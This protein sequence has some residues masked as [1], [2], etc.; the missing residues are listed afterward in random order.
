MKKHEDQTNNFYYVT[1]KAHEKWIG[2]IKPGTT[3][4]DRVNK[5]INRIRFDEP[6]MQLVGFLTIHN[7]NKARLEALE[8]EIKADLYDAGFDHFGNDH[9]S[10]HFN[11]KGNRQTQYN[12]VALAI[13]AKA[14]QYCDAHY[15]DYELTWCR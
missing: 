6:N 8:H 12:I 13:L 15:L 4:Q 2:V 1:I 5:R 11:R 9:F 7:T 14:M 3:Q 10:F